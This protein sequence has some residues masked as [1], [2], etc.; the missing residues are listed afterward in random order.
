MAEDVVQETLI[1]VAKAIRRCQAAS[2]PQ[3]LAWVRT[4]ARNALTDM[5]RSPTTGMAA[6]LMAQDYHDEMRETANDWQGL[7][8]LPSSPA[9]ACLLELVMDVYGDAAEPTGELFWLR[10]IAGLEWGE[11]A[12][13]F[14]TTTAGAKRR[15]Q[16]A[17]ATLQREVVSRVA[18]LPE[19]LQQNVQSLLRSFDFEELMESGESIDSDGPK[20]V[21]RKGKDSQS[22][23]ADHA[24]FLGGNLAATSSI[25]A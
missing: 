3:I 8:A 19:P 10:L 15:F 17:Q 12:V 9:R 25:A 16:R 1:R 20:H 22:S 21:R 18:Q 6:K 13:R 14:A 7:A 5:Y 24:V 11:I 4:I 23:S 2:D